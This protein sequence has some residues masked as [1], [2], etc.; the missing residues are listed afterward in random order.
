MRHPSQQTAPDIAL[1]EGPDGQVTLYIDGA[2]AMQAWERELMER[3]A[4]L[5]CEHGTEFLE[6]G[7]GLGL[8]ALT[9]SGRPTTTRHV[10]VEPYEEVID[11]FRSRHP[12]PPAALEI[13]RA[14]FFEYIETLPPESFDGIFFDP[15]LPA[16]MWKDKP[17]WHGVVGHMLRVLRSGGALVPFFLTSPELWRRYA[18]RF[19]RVL[20]ERHSYRAYPTTGYTNGVSG[21]AYVQCYV[22][23]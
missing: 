8:S 22:K 16:E 5:L 19:D 1:A 17:F 21:S 4:E 3:S 13:V 12:T 9:I 11:Y 15:A 7:L 10:V 23:D 14:D 18:R 6:A 2:Q 20:V